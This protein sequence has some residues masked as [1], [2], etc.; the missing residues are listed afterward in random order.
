MKKE[1]TVFNSIAEICQ[2]HVSYR[3]QILK[4][5]KADL[6]K[7]Y[8]GSLLGWAWALVKPSV[9][10]FVFWFA[11]SIGLRHGGNI[12]GYP[13]FLWLI[14]GFIPWFYM[15]DMINSGTGCLRSNRNLITKMK[16]PL[17]LI[18]TFTSLS[19]LTIHL[20]L[21][22]A[23]I[24]IYII[25][26]YPPDIYYLQLPLYIFMMVLWF[27]IWALF[28]GILAAMSKDFLN[29]IKS[30]SQALF[31]LSGIIYDVSTINISWLR[32]VLSYNPVTIAA[33]CYRHTFVDKI[34][35]FE[36]LYML[37]CYGIMLLA[38]LIAAIWA[39]RKFAKD[40]PD[41]I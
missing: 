13:F 10:I 20:F 19:K 8:R 6:D 33:T 34:W 30:L 4:F 25:A 16:F 7:S 27:T 39:Y 21:L 32:S 28:G 23:M 36:D 9:T 24:I 14:A 29:L 12:N 40:V 1:G 2:D 41:V 38:V 37:R 17:S 5:A 15:R 35:F 11:I 3:K 31:W 22:A 18:P 26:G